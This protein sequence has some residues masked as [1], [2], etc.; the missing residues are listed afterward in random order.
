MKLFSDCCHCWV[1]SAQGHC[2]AGIGDD[3]FSPAS[4]EEIIRRLDEGEFE[5]KRKEMIKFLE[6]KYHYKYEGKGI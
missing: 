1:C 3:D 4:K 2:L 5:S 6:E